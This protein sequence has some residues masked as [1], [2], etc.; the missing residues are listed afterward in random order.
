MGEPQRHI[1]TYLGLAQGP[2]RNLQ[3][4]QV[5]KVLG[6][7]DL[8]DSIWPDLED[9]MKQASERGQDTGATE[10]WELVRDYVVTLEEY[11]VLRHRWSDLAD[12]SEVG[13]TACKALGDDDGL[14]TTYRLRGRALAELGEPGKAL[15]E[16]DRGFNHAADLERESGLRQRVRLHRDKARCYCLPPEP[17]LEFALREVEQG[18]RIANNLRNLR[19][20]KA[21]ILNIKGYIHRMKSRAKGE[22]DE[23]LACFQESFKIFQDLDHE[24]LAARA[25]GN[26]GLV[27]KD[28]G[29][30]EQAR[31]CYQKTLAVYRQLGEKNTIARVLDNLGTIYYYLADYPEAIRAYTDSLTMFQELERQVEEARQLLNLVEVY[32]KQ[33]HLRQAVRCLDQ[34]DAL[35]QEVRDVAGRANACRLRAELCLAKGD[36]EKAHSLAKRA[37]GLAEALDRSLQA[38]FFATLA[39]V[40]EARGERAQA[41]DEWQKLLSIYRD[42][43]GNRFL[44]AK[45]EAKLRDLDADTPDAD[46]SA[47]RT[48]SQPESEGFPYDVFISYSHKDK[49]WVCN[50]LLPHLESEDLRVCIDYRDFEIGAPSLV[51]MEKAVEHSRKTLLVLTPNWVASEWAEF[52]ALLILTKDPAGRGRRILPLMVKPCEL[53][54][55]LQI[56][57]YLDLT[58]PTE[59]DFQMQRLVATI[60]STPLQ[61]AP[62][63]PTP[64]QRLVPPSRP[65]ARGFS[66]ERGLAALG[67]LL[68]EADVETHLNFAVLESRLLVNLQ[69]EHLYGTYEAIRSER[70]RIV[71]EL[72]RLALS[73]LGIPFNDL[74]LGRLPKE[75]E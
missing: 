29:N 54:D 52:E 21:E 41:R 35:L 63:E 69:D 7:L 20:E 64:V 8:L 19:R 45:V 70:A 23:S 4:G 2:V 13:Q 34:A 27:H 51:N 49:V 62:I 74:A 57:T 36:A 58:D 46:I 15:L 42:E 75:P 31:A 16:F 25:I 61:P 73:H 65:P 6:A 12:W 14:V 22:L 24:V 43:Q 39:R 48:E 5:D 28:R 17:N 72:N 11:F 71:Q 10:A 56:F 68:A 1:G 55:R 60:C 59:F 67:E 37:V 33:G 53:P 30:Y 47:G 44:A 3:S 40:H 50:R 18:L 38:D 26:V 9:G 32:V 66:Y